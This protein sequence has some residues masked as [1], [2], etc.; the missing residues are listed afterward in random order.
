MREQPH[1]FAGW[2]VIAVLCTALLLPAAAAA[3]NRPS[4]ASTA[5]YKAFIAYVK[6]LDGLVG[7]ATAAAQKAT[8]ESELT[9]KFKATTHK[10]NALFKRGSDEAQAEANAKFK[11]QQA[12]IRRAE[13]E[14]A[15]AIDAEFAA[16]IKKAAESFRA[17]ASRARLATK[18]TPIGLHLMRKI[19]SSR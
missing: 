9:A 17:K 5:Q 12:T 10:A 4:L 16:K 14:E 7:Q 8:Y 11:E 18:V 15:D 13:G 3:G 2:T 1:R 19:P 6:K